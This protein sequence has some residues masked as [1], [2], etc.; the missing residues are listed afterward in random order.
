MVWS[1]RGAFWRKGPHTR[2]LSASGPPLMND[3]LSR[4]F[5]R[6]ALSSQQEEAREPYAH[7]VHRANERM[8]ERRPFRST[9]NS[10]PGPAIIGELKRASPSAGLIARDFDPAKIAACYERADVDAVS[11]LT[12]SEH[13]LGELGHLD[14]VRRQTAKPILRKDFLSTPYQV[15]Q[16]AAYGADAILLIA[17]ALSDNRITAAVEECRKYD[18]EALVEV[19]D[20]HELQRAVTL[21]VTLIGIN[22]RNLRTFETDL[23]V[24]ELLLPGVP[25][26]ITVVSESGMRSGSDIARLYA[27]GVRAFLIGESLMRADDPVEFVR[28]LKSAVRVS[29]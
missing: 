27:L 25:G 9:L 17:A 5:A 4:I 26:G 24:T 15:A 1:W 21:G 23:A 19:H 16:S 7:L 2:F 13:F 8:S 28:E 18:L 14:D 29:M 22:N 12:E 20:G 10:A 6:K 3:I 11:V